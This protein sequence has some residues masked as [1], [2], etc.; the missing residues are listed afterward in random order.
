MRRKNQTIQAGQIFGRNGQGRFRERNEEAGG[1]GSGGFGS[2][3]F[4]VIY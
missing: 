2:K 4:M 3:G 1:H